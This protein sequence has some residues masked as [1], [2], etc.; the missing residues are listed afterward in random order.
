M[1]K[2][3]CALINR[4]NLLATGAAAAASISAPTHVFAQ[5]L[6]KT[7]FMLAWL[8]DGSNYFMY[9]AKNLGFFK[10]RGIDL[11]LSRGFGSLAT[12]EAVG[13]GKFDFGMPAIVTGI[14]Q[15]VQGLPI[16]FLSTMGYDLTMGIVALA[17]LP[18]K[19]PKDLEGRKLGSTVAS[20]E[21]PFID[22]YLRK[23][24]VDPSKVE[25]VQL[26]AQVRNRALL[27]KQ[28]DAISAFAG[29]SVPSIAAQG[30]GTRFFAYSAVGIDTYSIA[31][32]TR[33]QTVAA[34]PQLCQAVVDASLEGFVYTLKDP[35]AALDAF[36]KELPEVAA[37]PAAK[38]QA[39]IGLGIYALSAL[40]SPAKQNGIAWL[41]P[42]AIER[43]TDL[44]MEFI[45]PKG[46]QRPKVDTLFTNRFVGSARLTD[47][48]W[49]VALKRFA[50][51]R[52]YVG[53]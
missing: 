45:S 52:K 22:H 17:D 18:I 42:G 23:A 15:A 51:Y 12:A 46:A 41:D 33:P 30:V 49:D 27:T 39:R 53:A 24:G 29:S 36:A 1:G 11:E 6:R 14:Q 3:R 28:V 32:A 40:M 10:K 7:T 44:V 43:Q 31:I 4:R 25:R 26:D 8:P 19:S 34:E 21:Y 13:S 47:A 5:T 20:G 16:T 2:H 50:P 35:E 38:D 9:A 37:N 48:E